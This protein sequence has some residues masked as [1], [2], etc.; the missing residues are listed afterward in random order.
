MLVLVA[1]Q[2][3]AEAGSHPIARVQAA[4]AAGERIAA[5]ARPIERVVAHRAALL[6]EEARNAEEDLAGW[7]LAPPRRALLLPE[8]LRKTGKT[9]WWAG[10]LRHTACRRS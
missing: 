9:C 4:A 2:L 7:A 6:P 1:A 5:A 10:W 8:G 3:L